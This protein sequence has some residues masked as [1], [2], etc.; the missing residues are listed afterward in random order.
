MVKNF[1]VIEGQRDTDWL[2][3]SIPYEVRN[4][5]GDWTSYLPPGE[6]QANHLVD[7]MACVT[8]SALNSI[9][10]QYKFLTGIHREFADR[11]TAKM[12]G[13]TDKGN[14]LYLVG[15]SIREHSDGSGD[16]LVDELEWPAPLDYTWGS[17]Y[18]EI[19]QFIKD[20]GRQFLKEWKIQYEFINFDRDSLIHHLKQAPIQVVIPGHAV[21][22]FTSTQQ[23]TKYFDS[24][25]PYQK[26]WSEPNQFGSA[27]KIVLTSKKVMS[28]I[29]VRKLYRLAFYREP[30]AGE[31]GF[32]VG[33][34]LSEFLTVALKDRAEFLS[35]P[36]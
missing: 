2:G 24:Y 11:F 16:G 13:T 35:S 7:T 32:W 31:L 33:R 17:Y 36:I 3:G 34:S 28:D 5:S 1:G 9:E 27:L 18:E 12:S 6:W 14:Y 15:D 4:P 29:E 20:K 22:A 26:E 23:V 25:K 19:P 30:D 21:L 8:F 10:T